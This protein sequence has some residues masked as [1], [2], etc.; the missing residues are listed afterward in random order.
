MPS[1]RS[2]AYAAAQD[3]RSLEDCWWYHSMDLPGFGTVTGQWDLRGRFDEYVGH[4][5]LSGRTVL[6]VG[7]AS[8]FLSLEAEK[9]GAIVTGFDADSW[10]RYQHVPSKN[11]PDHSAGFPMMRRGYWLAHAANKSKTKVI[12][13]DIYHLSEQA[14][15]HD[16]VLIGQILVHLRDPL[17]ALHQ[18][19]LVAKEMMIITE[20]SFHADQPV[21]RFLGS[22]QSWYSWW[23]LSDELYRRWLSLLAFEI[24]SVTQNKFTCTQLPDPA[25]VWTF[26]ARRTAP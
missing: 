21:S 12:Y 9:R 22:E 24:V 6:D 16:V 23:H 20:G 17:E 13:G 11:K 8:G 3:V 14:P 15:A 4:V 5:P 1:E 18:A 19:S 7:T 10:S 2:Y 25:E 26:V